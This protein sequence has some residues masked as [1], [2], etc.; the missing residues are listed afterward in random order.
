MMNCLT[1]LN[2]RVDEATTQKPEDYEVVGAIGRVER[3][4]RR[5][6]TGGSHKRWAPLALF[7]GLL[8]KA[9]SEF[10]VV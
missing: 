1:M 6:T 9:R 5:A 8:G 4:Q 10:S 7:A 3:T 2:V